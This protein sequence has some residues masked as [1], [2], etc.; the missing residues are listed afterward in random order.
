MQPHPERS[1]ADWF[2][3]ARRWYVEKHQGCPRCR[4]RHCVIRSTWQTRLEFHCTECHFACAEDTG[5]CTV[6]LSDPPAL[7][8]VRVTQ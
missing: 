5:T 4:S 2:A 6:D 8:P 1:A 3:E 7:T